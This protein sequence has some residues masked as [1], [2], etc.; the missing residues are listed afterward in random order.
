MISFSLLNQ[1]D[2]NS[3]T[4]YRWL[5]LM[6]SHY[7]W[8]SILRYYLI[9]FADDGR[10]SRFFAVNLEDSVHREDVNMLMN[11]K[12]IVETSACYLNTNR[13][14]RLA[15]SIDTRWTA[16]SHVDGCE[17]YFVIAALSFGNSRAMQ[18]RFYR[19]AGQ[20][21]RSQASGFDGS[22]WYDHVISGMHLIEPEA[23]QQ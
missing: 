17:A 8:S 15:N 7:H 12:P 5:N 2:R 9:Y 16:L 20:C 14:R 4:Q 21:C 13:Y 3:E 23:I 6:A 22:M 11:C 18:C 10:F 1:I 19:R